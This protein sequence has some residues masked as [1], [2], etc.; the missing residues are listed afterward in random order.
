MSAARGSGERRKPQTRLTFRGWSLAGA[1][2]LCLLLAQVMGRKDLL[3]LGLFLLLLPVLAL[4]SVRLGV[5]GFT[6]R[7]SFEPTVV[8]AGSAASV[9]LSISAPSRFTGRLRMQEGLPERFGPSPQFW[10]PGQ[11]HQVTSTERLSRYRYRIH[12][13]VRGQFA[14]GP[15]SAEFSDAF[16]L[17]RTMLILP[18]VSWLT[19]TPPCLELHTLQLSGAHGVDGPAPTRQRANPS[20]DDVMTRTYRHGDPMRRV[21]WPAT[22]R[23]GQLMVRQEESVTT[24]LA[25]LILDQRLPAFLPHGPGSRQAA[26][27][28]ELHSSESFEWAVTAT[29]SIGA[30]LLQ[31]GF[32]LRFLDLFGSAGAARSRPAEHPEQEYLVGSD[33]AAELA[34]SLAALELPRA[35]GDQGPGEDSRHDAGLLS[36]VSATARRGPV[37]AVLGLLDGADAGLLAPLAADATEACALIVVPAHHASDPG[38]KR[39]TELLRHA[40]W[41]VAV[42]SADSSLP[43]LWLPALWAQLDARRNLTS[44]GGAG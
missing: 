36:T 13:A 12:P 42:A 5:P 37:V 18:G 3:V 23:H 30:H 39:A 32:E 35:S 9:S 10:Y 7:R 6:V 43:A 4:A 25:T 38:L 40:G 11:A 33:G 26:A 1:G 28:P 31:H 16:G 2:V 21:H 27:H 8:V 17:S 19:V 22:A 34:A 14:V 20:D 41:Q 44:G 24:P 15:V 29:N